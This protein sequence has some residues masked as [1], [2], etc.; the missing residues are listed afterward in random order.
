MNT[1]T[2]KYILIV[3]IIFLSFV[4][5]N[6]WQNDFV[7]DNE[8]EKKNIQKIKE[9][10]NQKINLINKNEICVETNL[11]KAKINLNDGN[12][13]NLLLKKYYK[14][15]NEKNPIEIFN[16]EQENLFFSQ[17]DL[18]EDNKQKE[19][20]YLSNSK[21]YKIK[22]NKDSL[23]ITL[24]CNEK[25]NLIIKKIYVFKN[26]SYTIDV[27]FYI[28]N[29]NDNI[30]TTKM[31][32]SII[33]EYNN[34]SNSL[35]TSKE[36]KNIA[37]YS[38]KNAYKKININDKFFKN[39]TIYGGWLASIDNYFISALIPD[40]NETNI[41]KIEKKN[42]NIYTINFY[43]NIE[44]IPKEIKIIKTELFVGP[45]IKEYLNKLHKGLDLSIDYGI[46][47]PIAI[48]IFLLLNKI[49]AIINNWGI[50]IIIIT[51]FIKILFFQL[52]SISYISLGKMKKIQ[53]KLDLIK[54]KYGENKR[55][56]SQAMLELY[57]KENVNPLSGCLPIIIQI[58][59]FISLY[60]V[61]LESIELRHSPF[62]LWIDD[63]SSKDKYYILPIIMSVTMFIQ[64]KLN[65]PIQDA[66]QRTVMM[67]MPFLFLIIFLQF[68]SGL[69][70]YWII[71]NI[72]SILQQWIITKNL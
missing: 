12:I 1:S 19:I 40:S 51:L 61:L 15:L 45:K 24:K 27:F 16:Y 68:P 57:K 60:Y 35:F 48:V 71:N 13:S 70:L 64:Q 67:F 21:E 43:R 59:V 47:W 11:V 62:L 10:K 18:Y 9:I 37:M 41:Y 39:E 20:K 42:Q 32:G 2:L 31:H 38:D 4:L 63:L 36:Y 56:L 25:D 23:I 49:Y 7:I 50:S 69:I 72:L 33:R 46:L 26:Y 29:I 3:S 30:K 58:P 14:N 53:P 34:Q 22:E 66:T 17:L 8:T 52:S 55:E 5:F 65:P 54:E 28:K 6:S 44:T